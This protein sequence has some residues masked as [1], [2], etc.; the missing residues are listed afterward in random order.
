MRPIA[1]VA[2]AFIGSW[3]FSASAQSAL[4]SVELKG[5]VTA[6]D[7]A[8]AGE[9]IVGEPFTFSYAFEPTSPDIV[10]ADDQA[11]Y[12]ASIKAANLLVGD[13][14]LVAVGV[15]NIII[16]DD[17][18]GHDLYGVL[19][20]A[21]P[22]SNTRPGALLQ[23]A[24]VAG[25]IPFGITVT[26]ADQDKVALASDALPT[27]LPDL[28]LFETREFEL[29]F[30]ESLDFGRAFGTARVYGHIERVTFAVATA[31]IPEPTHPIVFMLA[32]GCLCL[33]RGGRLARWPL[34]FR[35]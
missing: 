27:A 32:L 4:V 12:G 33:A 6:R 35:R 15:G 5:I 8:L 10:P 17:A 21:P 26:L 18:F 14:A 3:F 30:A 16:R 34:P 1:A 9:F 25:R 2:A 7:G 24:S 23:G 19:I 11:F 13:Y 20:E 22:F 28:S 29:A 31:S